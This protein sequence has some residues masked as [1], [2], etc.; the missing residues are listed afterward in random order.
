[1]CFGEIL[2]IHSIC[3]YLLQLT[4]INGPSLFC[5]DTVAHKQHFVLFLKQ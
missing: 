5:Y 3:S 1:V 4:F 2:K